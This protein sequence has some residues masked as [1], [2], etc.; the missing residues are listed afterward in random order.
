M[1][2]LG[3]NFIFVLLEAVQKFNAWSN[4][5]QR[6]C[7]PKIKLSQDVVV[8]VCR[9]K[10]ANTILCA[11]IHDHAVYT[12]LYNALRHWSSMWRVYRELWTPYW[13]VAVS[14]PD[15]VY[16]AS[17]DLRM[18][19]GGGGGAFICVLIFY[20]AAILIAV[21]SPSSLLL[22]KSQAPTFVRGHCA[23][24]SRNKAVRATRK[25]LRPQV[26]H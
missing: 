20:K 3:I 12:M 8:V 26:A 14:I 5:S 4:K 13:S 25:V 11:R 10:S 2:L 17:I 19:G 23:C 7:R 22:K 1:Q 9:A 16:R 21:A 6:M 15:T 24:L 18:P